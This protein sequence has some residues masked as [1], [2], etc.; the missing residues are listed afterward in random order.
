MRLFCPTSASKLK[1]FV[2]R[3]H[4]TQVSNYIGLNVHMK[5]I[6]SE[7]EC[8]MASLRGNRQ[9]E[10]INDFQLVMKLKT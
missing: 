6:H 1:D 7:I 8:I 3:R 9:T 4:Q 5:Q 2:H 10:T